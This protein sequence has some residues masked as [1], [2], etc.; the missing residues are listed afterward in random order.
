M[1][2]AGGASGD[3]GTNSFVEIGGV[4]VEKEVGGVCGLRLVVVVEVFNESLVAAVI[5]S[6]ALR[7][8]TNTSE[9]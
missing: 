6:A 8:F 2:S 7:P 1:N 4:C 9:V 5:S 3:C